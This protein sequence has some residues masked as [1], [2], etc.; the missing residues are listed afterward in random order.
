MNLRMLPVLF[1]ALF[2][3][4]VSAERL[5]DAIDLPSPIDTPREVDARIR[6][7]R[8]HYEPFMADHVGPLEVRETVDVER[9]QFRL[10]DDNAGQGAHWYADWERDGWEKISLPDYR[11]YARGWYRAEFNLP[12]LKGRQAFLVCDG[13]DYTGTIYLCGERVGVQK[14]FPGPFEMALPGAAVGVNRLYFEIY[15]DEDSTERPVSLSG[16]GMGTT[17]HNERNGIDQHGNGAGILGGVRVELRAPGHFKH[18]LVVPE[19]PGRFVVDVSATEAL[20]QGAARIKLEVLPKNFEDASAVL[21]VAKPDESPRAGYRRLALDVPNPRLWTPEATWLY[22]VRLTAL[23]ERGETLDAWQ[24]TAG[25]R[26]VAM[27]E[28]GGVLLN[29]KPHYLRGS[30]NFGLFHLDSVRADWDAMERDILLFR[31]ANLEFCRNHLAYAHPRFY[32]MCDVYGLM[33]YQDASLQW[34]YPLDADH[35]PRPEFRRQMLSQIRQRTPVL[36]NHPSIIIWEIMNEFWSC[37]KTFRSECVRL[38]RELD[39]TRLL[40]ANSGDPAP[41]HGESVNDSHNYSGWYGAVVKSND[42]P[43][44]AEVMEDFTGIRIADAWHDNVE[45]RVIQSEFGGTAYPDWETWRERFPWAPQHADDAF[46]PGTEPRA[47]CYRGRSLGDRIQTPN[48]LWRIGHWTTAEEWIA[49]SQAYQDFL[50]R[51]HTDV[52]RR[53]RADMAGYNQFHLIDPAPLA[54]PKAIMDCQRRPKLAYYGLLQ[55]S[56]PRR[57]NLQYTRTRF[58]AGQETDGLAVWVYN[59]PPDGIAGTG[60]LF[61]V[62][63]QDN[64]LAKSE[65]RIDVPGDSSTQVGV[66]KLRVPAEYSG[67]GRVIAAMVDSDGKVI[68]FDALN[69]DVYPDRKLRVERLRVYDPANTTAPVLKEL[70]IDG[71]A[72]GPFLD[73]GR[74]LEYEDVLLVGEFGCSGA[75]SLRE[76]GAEYTKAWIERGGTLVVLNQIPAFSETEKRLPHRSVLWQGGNDKFTRFA[77]LSFLPFPLEITKSRGTT[78]SDCIEWDERCSAF[79]VLDRSERRFW[80]DYEGVQVD[81]PFERAEGATVLVRCGP[82]MSQPAVVRYNVGKGAIIVSQLLLLERAPH[83]P[84]VRKW[85]GLLLN[86]DDLVLDRDLSLERNVERTSKGATATLTARNTGKQPLDVEVGDGGRFRES[87]ALAAGEAKKW[88][89]RIDAPESG[90]LQLPPAVARAGSLTFESAPAL[91]LPDAS[92]KRVY[93][94]DVGLEGSPVAKGYLPLLADMR[95][96]AERGYGWTAGTTMEPRDRGGDD[97]LL[98]DFAFCRRDGGLRIDL[99]GGDYHVVVIAHDSE[100]PVHPTT[101]V[102]NGETVFRDASA[103]T[104]ETLIKEFDVKVQDQGLLLQFSHR[105]DNWSIAGLLIYRN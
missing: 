1:L 94:F 27:A 16:K 55:S 5:R 58:I 79:S 40:V 10:D 72:T 61:L 25:L 74:G 86:P 99:P 44:H 100:Y 92:E 98:R 21:D 101:L 91:L 78:Y 59:D 62:D 71:F 17:T 83:D 66:A 20:W 18:A 90:A 73:S 34:G 51:M 30:C 76:L 6:D 14:D 47:D 22:V 53:R 60:R 67:V 56:A 103:R 54:W 45:G 28:D 82:G 68:D 88:T 31:A 15:N 3:L 4:S 32:E 96:T 104:G 8:D 39:P 87:V 49:A 93:A 26:T 9:W 46:T 84:V 75:E 57:I 43:F 13:V 80:N 37:S 48:L 2:S 24:T 41:V 97:S 63:G 12:D 38:Q 36:F 95:Y 102:A 50:T 85:L 11:E 23:N 33:L 29:G 89:Y 64:V 81:Y 77:D 52:W 70:G 69:V 19:L 65:C 42:V 105:G 7:L 35:E